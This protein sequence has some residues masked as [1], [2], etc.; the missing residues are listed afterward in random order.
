[1]PQKIAAVI[2]KEK[3]DAA[4]AKATEMAAKLDRNNHWGQEPSH[5][6]RAATWM[7]KQ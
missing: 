7:I 4:S 2:G 3:A 1:M 5:V 6:F